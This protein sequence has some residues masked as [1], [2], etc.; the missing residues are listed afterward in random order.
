MGN[1]MKSNTTTLHLTTAWVSGV[2]IPA[3]PF[4]LALRARIDYAMAVCT[5]DH[6]SPQWHAYLKSACET[7]FSL[8]Y[9]LASIDET[10]TPTCSPLLAD[11]QMLCDAFEDGVSAVTFQRRLDDAEPL[12]SIEPESGVPQ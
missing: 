11:V 9:G 10:A 4:D 1:I 12:S 3:D 6:G 8:G 7:A 2:R 5:V